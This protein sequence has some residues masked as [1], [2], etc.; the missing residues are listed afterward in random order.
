VI[1]VKMISIYRDR[2]HIDHY[3][4]VCAG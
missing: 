2:C 1:N 3:W 4:N